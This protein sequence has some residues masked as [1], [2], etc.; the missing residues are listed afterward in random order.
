MSKPNNEYIE[1]LDGSLHGKFIPSK[2]SNRASDLIPLMVSPTK[3][4]SAP[5]EGAVPNLCRSKMFQSII[6][7]DDDIVSYEMYKDKNE[8]EI[9]YML[10]TEVDKFFNDELSFYDISFLIANDLRRSVSS[11][12]TI[13]ST[14]SK[15]SSSTNIFLD[16]TYYDENYRI[17][18]PHLDEYFG[19]ANIEKIPINDDASESTQKIEDERIEE[20]MDEQEEY[21]QKC[22]QEY[23]Q[24]Q[25]E[26]EKSEE[27]RIKEYEEEQES[28]NTLDENMNSIVDNIISM[29]D[30]NNDDRDIIIISESSQ[31]LE[32]P[33]ITEESMPMVDE[34]SIEE[35]T[36]EP[37]EEP[38]TMVTEKP[39]EEPAPIKVK[40]E[41]NEEPI[42]FSIEEPASI[43][44]NE[45]AASFI[46]DDVISIVTDEP[47]PVFGIEST[48]SII[49]DDPV[50]IELNESA[51][52]SPSSTAKKERH[53]EESDNF[54]DLLDR[55]QKEEDHTQHKKK[56]FCILS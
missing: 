37:T 13:I 35:P 30:E 29:V 15:S 51:P 45:S 56:N 1:D 48:Y 34:E 41:A 25:Y 54:E 22:I 44:V 23:E 4:G 14:S 9:V 33:T 43:K 8:E 20:P 39:T 50:S 52:V 11:Y 49:T 16:N 40:E 2:D 7:N 5:F 47:T 21:E 10:K 46:S 12:D 42:V 32:L 36:E 17:E 31:S 3:F 26:M 53:I 6:T 24:Q 55:I 18:T 19:V 38:V 27:E 28:M